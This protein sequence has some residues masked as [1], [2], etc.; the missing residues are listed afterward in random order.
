[1]TSL[2]LAC[3]YCSGQ[4]EAAAS[5]AAQVIT[6]P[7]CHRPV[8]IPATNPPPLAASDT[9]AQRGS[10]TRS[11]SPPLPSSP[12]SPF[13]LAEPKKVVLN[14]QGEPIELR[15]LTPE[16]RAR[17]R[18]RLNWIFALVGMILLAIALAVL[19]RLRP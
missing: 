15:R 12:G 1:M 6:C 5:A 13:D 17:Y 10:A 4:I 2:A 3:P 19:L 11:D 7:N 9:V 16:E 14:R 18:R 8:T